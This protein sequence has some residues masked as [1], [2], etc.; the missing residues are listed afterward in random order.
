MGIDHAFRTP[1]RS[2]RVDHICR[3]RG[4]HRHGRP[5]RRRHG[6]RRV[7]HH[8]DGRGARHG[9][10]PARLGQHQRHR[11]VVDHPRHAL[12]W[13]LRIERHVRPTGLHH[14]EQCHDQ[15]HA[16]LQID[17]DAH[18]RADPRGA[19]PARQRLRPRGQRRVAHGLVL[20][21]HR[22]RIGRLRDLRGNPRR[23]QRRRIRDRRRIPPAHH[24][25]PL[26]GRQQ[27]Q[28]I[29]PL[30]RRVRHPLQHARPVP[31]QSRRRLR[32]EQI[33][34]VHQLARELLRRALPARARD[35]IWRPWCRRS[36]VAGAARAAPVAA[37][38]RS[39]ASTSPGT[40]AC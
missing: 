7:V 9:G 36:S 24:L 22:D 40:A 23:H 32:V 12:G 21:H 5:L 3:L 2:R 34:R 10:A 1:C 17:P 26:L 30:L 16:A 4:G 35:R 38:P 29:H 13:P 33:G 20:A 28:R 8:D 37:P 19:Q 31:D 11:R 25:R 18:L 39:A 27:L 6:W 15:R 14:A